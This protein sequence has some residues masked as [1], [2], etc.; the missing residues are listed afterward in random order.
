MAGAPPDAVI[1]GL[2]NRGARFRPSDWN[3]RLAGLTSAFGADR[4]LT[5]SPL[6]HPM[7]VGGA[8]ALV[9]GGSLAEMEPR[10]WQ[11]LMQFAR[12]NDLVVTRVSGAL[13]QP[14]AIVAPSV[15][16]GG[17]PREPV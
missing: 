2:T 10:L 12:D 9:V 8:S 16:R 4:K 7:D 6:V 1:F 17:E 5:Y 11:F 14:H 15:A 3:E 13:A